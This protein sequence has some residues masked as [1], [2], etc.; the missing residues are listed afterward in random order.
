VL[1]NGKVPVQFQT[2]SG[3]FQGTDQT[4]ALMQ[5]YSMGQWGSRSPKIRALALNIVTTA[6]VQEKDYI[7][8]MVAIHEYVRDQIRYTR[9]VNGQETLLPPEELAFN[10]QA[11]DC[12]DKSMLEAALLGSIGIPSRFV[13]IGITPDRMSHVYLQAKPQDQW[14]PLD[15]I[16]KNKPAGWEVPPSVVKVRKVY[17]EN[18]PQEM[19]VSNVNGLGDSAADMS[20]AGGTPGGSNNSS[21]WGEYVGFQ[22][23][24]FATS[25]LS[26]SPKPPS[27][28]Q[29][30]YII[31]DSMSDSDLPIDQL[32]INAP[33]FPQQ[34]PGMPTTV[35]PAPMRNIGPGLQDRR[36]Q[37]AQSG[38]PA[39]PNVGQAVAQAIGEPVQAYDPWN[40]PHVLMPDGSVSQPHWFTPS[41]GYP[42]VGCS[43]GSIVKP[44]ALPPGAAPVAQLPDGSVVAPT[45][46]AGPNPYAQPEADPDAGQAVAQA[47][48]EPVQAYDAWNRPHVVMPDGSITQPH[49]FTPS[50]RAPVVSMPDG[51]LAQPD[52]IPAHQQTT[53]Q[54][55]DGS[56]AKPTYTAGPN[57]YAQMAQTGW[58][59][60]GDAS[61]TPMHGLGYATD[62]T[63]IT[64][65]PPYEINANMNI[66]PQAKAIAI[67]RKRSMLT[68]QQ[69]QA[70]VFNDESD[71]ANQAA[72]NPA[73]NI[74]GIYGADELAGM[75]DSTGIDRQ[76]PYANMQRPAL[77]QTPE[78]I[79]NLFTR[80]NM[81][82]R[83]DKGDTIV[84]KGLWD[85]AEKPPI[86]PYNPTLD[87][88][89]AGRWGSGVAGLGATGTS[90]SASGAP[91]GPVI[92]PAAAVT[93]A[94]PVVKQHPLLKSQFRSLNGVG[95]MPARS[96]SG[97]GVADLADAAAAAP[98]MMPMTTPTSS[99]APM[100]P[101]AA[102]ISLG[103]L[104][105][106]GIGA[107]LLLKKRK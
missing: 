45:F 87:G 6:G 99:S 54:M 70:K 19:A 9:D 65:G 68:P 64:A 83:T 25:H 82:L 1:V 36:A 78:G 13:T 62:N 22:Q 3:G 88:Y 30:P 76:L 33:V 4:V 85:L 51:T 71:E 61:Y 29:Q 16:M 18:V 90:V 39:D 96:I 48:G 59:A 42:V 106:V 8:E 55:P 47:I 102:G 5:Q 28:G 100:I 86:R 58:D 79:D 98:A 35:G 40:R 49:W 52:P 44:G 43:D 73:T 80:P 92:V 2:L 21:P 34:T 20:A 75:G 91:I 24:G 67:K 72:Q 63:S 27:D 69:V 17:D 57:P 53:V 103:A 101:K 95:M 93:P 10:S 46:V 32:S 97:P 60:G 104:A 107:Y 56:I 81:V 89:S 37:I 23:G 38:V 41:D 7:G 66:T 105:V 31:T 84:Y 94:A 11:G 26:P 14:V 77:A 15:P 50:T 74:S 12:D